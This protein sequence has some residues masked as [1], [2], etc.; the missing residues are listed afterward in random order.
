VCAL[1]F[2]AALL[3]IKSAFLSGGTLVAWPVDGLIIGL[4]AAPQTKRPWMIM[5]AGLLGALLAFCLVGKQMILGVSR[6]GLMTLAIPIVYMTTRFLVRQ[7]SI[8]EVKALLPFLVVCAAV[9]FATALVRSVCVHMGWGFPIGPLTLTT[10]AATFVGD[11]LI[12]PL[13]LMLAQPHGL[14]GED[15][16][17]SSLRAQ[18][19]IWG[20]VAVYIVAMTAAFLE[21]R[22]P[23][24]YLVPL[25]LVLVAHVV[26]FRAM[27]VVILATA[28]VSVGLT[29]TGHGAISRCPGDLKDKV[30]LTQAFLVVVIFTTLPFSALRADRDRWRRTIAAALATAR[31]ASEA[32]SL[33]LATIS[34]EIRTPLNGVLGMAQAM[35]M[36]ELTDA[37]RERLRVLRESGRSLMW[38]LNDVLD[39]AKIEA[40][41]IMLETIPFDPA[42]V[43]VAIVAQ[44]EVLA[45]DK[46]LTLQAETQGPLGCYEGDPNRFRQIVQ[47]LVSNAIKFTESGGVSISCAHGDAG[48]IVQ[49]LDTG[50]GI[51]ADKHGALFEKFQQADASTTRRFGG[52]GL[53]LAI[54]RELARAM[55]GDVTLKSAP[56]QGSTFTFLAPLP[57]S[58]H[59]RTPPLE[60]PLETRPRDLDLRVLAA[61]DNLTNQL[62]L[63][64]LLG[65]VGLDPAIVANGAEAVA[66]WRTADWDVILMDIQMPVMDGPTAVRLIRQEETLSGRR[67]AMIVALTANTMDHQV[68]EYLEMGM[69]ACLPKPI[70]VGALFALLSECEAGRAAGQNARDGD[71]TSS[72]GE[73]C[74]AVGG[75]RRDEGAGRAHISLATWP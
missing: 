32:K 18:A 74:E 13:I 57:R 19:I 40:G 47:N 60:P 23:L 26:D 10:A 61:E 72:C 71:A 55:N 42:D 73:P 35:S 21:P 12:A 50:I 70:S 66:A 27:V 45:A 17:S 39:L 49:V 68:R 16:G 64:T 36:D 22:Y 53:G 65:V 51:P 69:D 28:V 48:L 24:A 11:A 6:V 14:E 54:S 38:L 58:D 43:I 1:A 7:R 30:L 8:A 62:V 15:A 59:A 41:E 44:N 34:H 63:K 20:V 31:S 5:A 25:G 67:R 33:F 56:G 46:G 3:A 52:T 4:M 29:F 2:A 75:P 9:G 37:Q